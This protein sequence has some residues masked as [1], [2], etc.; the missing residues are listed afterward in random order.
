MPAPLTS[1]LPGL[2][3]AQAA[4]I[5]SEITGYLESREFLFLLGAINTIVMGLSF[6]A[7]YAINKTRTGAAVAISKI[8][9]LTLSNLFYIIGA[10]II[11]GI[12]AFFIT[13]FLAKLISKRIHKIKYHKLSIIILIVLLVIILIFSGNIIIS[14]I[15]FL[16]STALGIS[17]ILL[18]IR[19]MHLMGSL[20]IPTILFYLL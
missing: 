6:I 7:L 16:T 1:F 15:I 5:G 17:C 3:S 10:I 20:L 14:L 18:G 8:T 2:G 13:I 11:S 19:R 12:I 4:V 9:E